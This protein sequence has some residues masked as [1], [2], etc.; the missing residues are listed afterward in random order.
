MFDAQPGR[1][2]DTGAVCASV[3]VFIGLCRPSY[4][5]M[6]NHG[7]HLVAWLRRSPPGFVLGAVFARDEYGR[8]VELDGHDQV[9][10]VLAS[11]A[12]LAGAVK[13]RAGTQPHI[14][15]FNTSHWIEELEQLRTDLPATLFCARTGGNEIIQAPMRD[16]RTCH[17]QR[18]QFW[19]RTINR[20][21]DVL[22]TNSDFTERRLVRMGIEPGRCV[23]IPGGVDSVLAGRYAHGRGRERIA[24][25][26]RVVWAGRFVAFKGLDVLLEA[27]HRIDDQSVELVMIGD[28]PLLPAVHEQVRRLRLDKQV[29]LPG[30]CSPC[31]SLQ[32]IAEADVY[33]ATSLAE[34]RTVTGGSYV[35]TETMGRSVME[36][37]SCGLR[38]VASRVGGLPEI[39]EPDL[40]ELVSPGDAQALAEAI[41][42]QLALPPLGEAC[43]RRLAARFAWS[44]V[45]NAYRDVWSRVHG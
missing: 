17:R 28:G 24:S 18:Q 1:V 5:G 21:I 19:S 33:A 15:F 29:C 12:A 13:E 6:E 22:V 35:H 45:F 20:H 40:G 43:R 30:A 42:R 23:R 37:L 16:M 41:V 32:A 31:R 2:A 4:G 39:V 8:T 44:T 14:L 9:V 36:A 38:V 11:P 7:R 3:F 26:R 27:M 10:R 25:A 34:V